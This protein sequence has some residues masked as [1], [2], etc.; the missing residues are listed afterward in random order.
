M[1]G[2]KLRRLLHL[3]ER[4]GSQRPE[5]ARF[6]ARL[7]NALRKIGEGKV[8]IEELKAGLASDN[9]L[10]VR[11]AFRYFAPFYRD[12][13]EQTGHFNALRK[14]L[15]FAVDQGVFRTPSLL[16]A[17]A[18]GGEAIRHLAAYLRN[19]GVDVT[20]NDFTPEML[21]IARKALTREISN[22]LQVTFT[23]RDIKD[24]RPDKRYGTVLVSFS[25][26]DIPEPK[27]DYYRRI[28][29]VTGSF[30]VLADEWPRVV[31]R[32][33]VLPGDVGELLD[34]AETE[35][36]RSRLN[37]IIVDVFGMEPVMDRSFKI[38]ELHKLYI[39]I[40]KKP[41]IETV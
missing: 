2:G 37:T 30:L 35:L 13:M 1:L 25:G 4:E 29:D 33:S 16:D 34:L 5:D 31:S 39:L 19:I 36:V 12:H 26:H 32:S 24:L 8:E 27:Q 28:V 15:D 11:R 7:E 38:D 3:R 6:N 40:Y 14:G 22:G 18:G 17:T 9:T 10:L 41:E 20:A 21:D 23:E